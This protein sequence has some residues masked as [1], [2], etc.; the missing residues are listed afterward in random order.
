MTGTRTD[1]RFTT[2]LVIRLRLKG[3]PAASFLRAFTASQ[4]NTYPDAILTR[5]HGQFLIEWPLI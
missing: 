2:H 5:C 3:A 1:M 4:D